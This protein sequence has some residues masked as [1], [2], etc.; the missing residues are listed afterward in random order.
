MTATATQ[1]VAIN[2]V[3]SAAVA[4]SWTNPETIARR[5]QRFTA[6]VTID[7]KVET[8]RS[9]PAALEALGVT[10]GGRAIRAEAR[11]HGVAVIEV[12]GK[13]VA[14]TTLAVH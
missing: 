1:T 10:K 4:A 2:P 6:L 3:M 8:F 11:D 9:V 7:G 12:N 5:T 14:I 13:S